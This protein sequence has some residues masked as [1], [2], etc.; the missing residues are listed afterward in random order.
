MYQYLTQQEIIQQLLISLYMPS[1]IYN[2]CA[3]ATQHSL[4]N[5]SVCQNFY[6]DLQKYIF[7]LQHHMIIKS[8]FLQ[9]QLTEQRVSILHQTYCFS[10]KL[11]V[12]SKHVSRW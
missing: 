3:G 8:L 9:L 4:N 12:F 10:T 1:T 5:L 2:T 7:K 11:I 6:R